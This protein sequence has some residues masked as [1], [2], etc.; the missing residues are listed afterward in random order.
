M[1][2][3][4]MTMEMICWMK[5]INQPSESVDP[6]MSPIR[7]LMDTFWWGVGDKYI[8]KSAVNNFVK[9]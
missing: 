3:V 4:D 2:I 5:S 9:Q 8:Q 7:S 6:L 1:V